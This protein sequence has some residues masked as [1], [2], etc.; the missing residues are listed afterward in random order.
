MNPFG[1]IANVTADVII[2]KFV[3]TVTGFFTFLGLGAN[4]LSFIWALFVALVI[5]IT[6]YFFEQEIKEM[7]LNLRG[8]WDRFKAKRKKK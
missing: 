3:P 4:V 8:K 2:L 7:S 5:K 1:K 6:L